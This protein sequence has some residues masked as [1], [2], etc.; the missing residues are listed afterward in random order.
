MKRGFKKL[1]TLGL[2]ALMAVSTFTTAFAAECAVTI[3]GQKPVSYSE[4]ANDAGVVWSSR[5]YAI[6]VGADKIADSD[7]VFF[8]GYAGPTSGLNSNNG[9]LPELQKQGEIFLAPVGEGSY[10]DVDESIFGDH[11]HINANDY[12][13]VQD[14]QVVYLPDS[15]PVSSLGSL[16]KYVIYAN[17]STTSTQSTGQWV[18]NA[19]GWWY[20]NGDGTYPSNTWKEINGKQYYFDGN[21]YMLHDTIT[22]DGFQVGSDGAWVQ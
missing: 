14:I 22:P 20:D 5:Y 9:K 11:L 15:I 17:G 21:G 7:I 13:L 6:V 2:S 16:Q 18:Q 1:A 19:I 10:A 4:M 12:D 3:F 8:N